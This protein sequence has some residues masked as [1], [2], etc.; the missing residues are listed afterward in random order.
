VASTH[1]SKLACRCSA[2]E[3]VQIIMFGRSKNIKM[4]SE[5]RDQLIKSF[6]TNPQLTSLHDY[7]KI[8]RPPAMMIGI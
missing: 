7:P 4:K 3:V 8:P 6:E 5:G 1:Y 2:G